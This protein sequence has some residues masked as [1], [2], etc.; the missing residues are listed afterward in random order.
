[1]AFLS[2]GSGAG[3]AART[4]TGSASGSWT[5]AL[6]WDIGT[7]PTNGDSLLFSAGPTR[8][9]TTNVTTGASNFTA[10]AFTGPN[11]FLFSPPLFLTNGL[12]NASGFNTTNTIH[13]ALTARAPQTWSVES[14]TTLAMSSNVNF[15]NVTLTAAVDGFLDWGG[16]VAATTGGTLN[17]TGGGKL[18]IGSAASVAQLNVQAGSVQVDGTLTGGLTISAG[19]TLE[20]S[21]TVPPFNCSGMVAPGSNGPAVL[22]IS[23]SNSVFNAGSFFSVRLDGVAPGTGHAQLKTPGPL[24]LSG[25]ALQVLPFFDPVLGQSFVIITNTGATAFSTTFSA[26]PEGA[27]QTVNSVRYRVSYVGGNGNDVTL[28]VVGFSASSTARIW[29]GGG[30]NGLWMNATNW[31]NNLVP[32]GGQ[33]LIFP[34][35]AAQLSSQNNFPI[36]TPFNALTFGAGGYNLSGNPL[37]LFGGVRAS[38]SSG[39]VSLSSPVTFS[40]AQT[41]RVDSSTATLHLKTNSTLD[42]TLAVEGAG[43]FLVE[44]NLAGVGGL[45][46]RG[47]L[48]LLA[49]NTYSGVTRVL[50][51]GTLTVS[52]PRALGGASLPDDTLVE[53]GGLLTLALVPAQ[54]MV[55]PLRLAGA[56]SFNTNQTWSGPVTLLGTNAILQVAVGSAAVIS[57]AIS[58]T[59]ARVS[60]L[61]P[62]TL[63]LLA[64]N[65]VTG[66]LVS[67]AGALLVNGSSRGLNVELQSGTLSGTGEVANL[68]GFAGSLHPGAGG[69]G[70]LTCSN[71]IIASPAMN[72]I[73]DVSASANNVLRVRGALQL[74]GTLQVNVVSAPPLDGVVTLI[75]KVSDGP[76]TGT[77]TELG[78]GDFVAIDGVYFEISYTGGDGNDVILRLLGLE[79]TGVTR[80]WD[81]GGANSFWSNPAN[82]Q[83]DVLPRGGDSILFPSTQSAADALI[84]NDL[85]AGLIFDRII[86]RN[87]A[88]GAGTQIYG[89]KVNLLSGLL[90]TN[91]DFVTVSIDLPLAMQSA[92]SFAQTGSPLIF[93][94]SITLNGDLS[95]VGFGNINASFQGPISG[96]GGL[97]KLAPG[98]INLSASNSFLGPVRVLAGSLNVAHG[99]ALGAPGG[100]T[101]LGANAILG[102]SAFGTLTESSLVLTGFVSCGGTNILSGH[103][104]L[105]AGFTDIFI[106]PLGA[107]VFAGPVDG[108]GG[109]VLRGGGRAEFPAT[110]S[111]SGPTL[112]E[113][114]TVVVPGSSRFSQFSL[115]SASSLLGGGGAVG[116]VSASAGAVIP[117]MIPGPSPGVLTAASISLSSSAQV[118][119]EL[120]G[121]VPGSGYDQLSVTGSVS[122]G[123]VPLRLAVGFTPEAGAVFTIINNRGAAA[124]D[125]IF[126]GLPEGSLL[127]TNGL[128]FLISYVGGDGNDVTLTRVV[129]PT[130]VTRVWDGGGA[131]NLWSNPLNWAGDAAP[132]PGD[133]VVFPAGVAKLFPTFDAGVNTVF[134]SLTFGAN[135]ELTPLA[136]H[137]MRL[138][139]G[140][141]ATHSSGLAKLSVPV[142]LDTNQLWQVAQPGGSLQVR[143]LN[144]GLYTLTNDSLGTLSVTDPI[145]GTGGLEFIGTGGT[146]LA[147]TNTFLGPVHIHEG[148]VTLQNSLGL[149]A[150]GSGTVVEAAATLVLNLPAGAA[151]L[152]PLTLA[153]Q[154]EAASNVTNFWNGPVTFLGAPSVSLAG[155][156]ARLELA[157]PATGGEL[158][159]LGSGTLALHGTNLAPG[160]IWIM[161]SSRVS[162]QGQL[163][164]VSFE[165]ADAG[166]LGGDGAVGSVATTFCNGCSI[167]PGPNN[168]PGLLVTS[169]LDLSGALFRADVAGP[170]PGSGHDQLDVQGTVRLTGASLAL[171]VTFLPAL[172][173]SLTI[174]NNDDTDSIEGTFSG[175]PQGALLTMNS[176]TF[177][178]SYVGGDGNDVTLTHVAAERFWNGSGANN[179]WT[180]AANWVGGLAPG[181]DDELIF[182]AGAARL[183]STNNFPTNTTFQRVRLLGP[184]YTLGG[185]PLTL[186]AGLVANYVGSSGLRLPLQLGAAAVVSNVTGTLSLEGSIQS[187]SGTNLFD[188]AGTTLIGRGTI[189]GDVRKRGSGQL[190]LLGFQENVSQIILDEGLTLAQGEWQSEA[191]LNGGNLGGTGYVAVVSSAGG[192]VIAPGTGPGVLS[193]YLTYWNP[194]V[195]LAVELNGL[196]PGTGHDQ[197]ASIFPPELGGATLAVS[198]GFTPAVGDTFVIMDS[199]F[200]S[201]VGTFAGLPEGALIT[202]GLVLLQISYVGGDGNDVTLTRVSTTP[203]STLQTLTFTGSGLPVLTGQGMPNMPYM[204]EATSDLNPPVYWQS[205]CTE[206]SD[207]AGHYQLT[208]PDAGSYST[209]YYRVLS[210]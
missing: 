160:L 172:G 60:Q 93:K 88:G 95:F 164:G 124:V 2:L 201:V 188:G 135:Y 185:N 171:N 128:K 1:M 149:G 143:G 117:G 21:G 9:L 209:R 156:S 75:D 45:D 199:V 202:N 46:V 206:F 92:M 59:N 10:L 140:V 131:N 187:V 69:A 83:G 167:E 34:A 23:S 64:S 137:S 98:N 44:S 165:I 155:A 86:F 176:V 101:F 106:T 129:P 123:G 127:L 61:Q 177:Q 189:V 30:A 125:G 35:G 62:G 13:A 148:R 7:R 157:W 29:D 91:T 136:G 90:A 3:A 186:R 102:L 24:N 192:G 15:T 68:T 190:Q 47:N 100:G 22:T 182:P 50:D 181:A 40:G 107:L 145:T 6:N 65:S 118:Q 132:E 8:L 49:S 63:Q 122:L 54:T 82:W 191:V 97:N 141:F 174:I 56:L 168:A 139:A 57:G 138:L 55:E 152:E 32:G 130:G 79:A 99:S 109:L 36:S 19:G 53:S 175:L 208:D 28:T 33:S 39:S 196:T 43:R 52:A 74:A 27:T 158:Q 161:E 153:G 114:A 105:G 112:I 25:A 126:A 203:A 154:V 195:T 51:G 87:G 72:F 108:P 5:N 48:T 120:N 119:L 96:Y 111:Y 84:T 183:T 163:T 134:H 67:E 173:A 169:N 103:V 17:K 104:T 85:P 193:V 121:L 166:Q 58:G 198:L 76:V 133:D 200:D 146:I 73:A 159:T 144:L 89:N 113:S 41:V 77:F 205:V 26:L 81:G 66:T 11:Y 110:N 94:N 170:T 31:S 78:E 14:Q 115:F 80:V 194:L 207:E 178:I 37:I 20:G 18:R 12:T 210:P 197:L 142:T 16:A 4:W 147:G 42:G 71:F 70:T 116:S 151:V 184:G 204:L 38:Q 180:T 179:L 150:A 162:V